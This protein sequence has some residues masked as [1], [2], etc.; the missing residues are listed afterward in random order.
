MGVRKVASGGRQ[1][2]IWREDVFSSIDTDPDNDLSDGLDVTPSGYTLGALVPMRP[3]SGA[4]ITVTP[5]LIENRAQNDR[6]LTPPMVAGAKAGA[7]DFMVDALGGSAELSAGEAPSGGIYNNLIES[8]YGVAIDNSSPAVAIA[9][10]GA[11][12]PTTVEAVAWGDYAAGQLVYVEDTTSGPAGQVRMTKTAV[13]TTLT[14]NRALSFTPA[15]GDI[16]MPLKTWAPHAN[17]TDHPTQYI[18]RLVRDVGD[19]EGSQ[20]DFS[21]CGLVMAFE[22]PEIGKIP[23]FHFTGAADD[24]QEY[25]T[26]SGKDIAVTPGTLAPP[27]LR[28]SKFYLDTTEIEI[29]SGGIDP[30]IVLAART[31][32]GGTQGRAGYTHFGGVPTWTM[33]ALYD[34]TYYTALDANTTYQ[35]QW[36]IGVNSIGSTDARAFNFFTHWSPALQIQN[37]EEIDVNG[38]VY[39]RLTFRAVRSQTA[40][41]EQFYPYYFGVAGKV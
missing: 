31:S 30:G 17:Y 41:Y 33:V 1:L 4:G 18:K 7:I 16:V 35:G 11:G 29:E 37:L 36:D 10:N 15:S 34:H 13:T 39:M 25:D 26:S 23:V 12:T 27:V 5:D 19:S 9:S 32:P 22:T 2:A 21:G 38:L 14:L 40:G 28:K 6:Q 20:I 8:A 24:W 3:E